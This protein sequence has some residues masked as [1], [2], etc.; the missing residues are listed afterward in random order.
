MPTYEY[1][2]GSCKYQFEQF[3]SI[4]ARPLRKCPNCGK[5]SVRRLVGAGAGIIFKGSGFYETDYRSESYKKAAQSETKSTTDKSTTEKKA[6][7]KAKDSSPSEK[8]KAASKE[9]K[10]S[11]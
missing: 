7:T 3:Q 5:A 10:K 11:A 4:K 1:K 2:C 9:K 6:E 8:P